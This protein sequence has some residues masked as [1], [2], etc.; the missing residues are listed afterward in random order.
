MFV[1]ACHES[2][3]LHEAIAIKQECEIGDGKRTHGDPIGQR[4]QKCAAR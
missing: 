4:M 2:R 3:G 1:G